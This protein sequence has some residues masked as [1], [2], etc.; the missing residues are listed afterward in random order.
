MLSK[1]NDEDHEILFAQAKLLCLEKD[2]NHYIKY[3]SPQK[4]RELEKKE[5]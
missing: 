5:E 3:S 1:I 2:S 4:Q